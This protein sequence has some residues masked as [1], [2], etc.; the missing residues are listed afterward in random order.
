MSPS[1]GSTDIVKNG[2]RSRAARSAERRTEPPSHMSC[3]GALV[4]VGVTTIV[5]PRHSNGSPDQARRSTWTYSSNSAPRRVRSTPA[6]SNSSCRY[7]RPATN[8]NRPPLVTSSVAT[9]SAKRIGSCNGTRSAFTV[10][11]ARLVA[12]SSKPARA[13]GADAKSTPWCSEMA[14]PAKPCSSAHRAISRHCAYCSASITVENGARRRSNR[15]TAVAM[16]SSTDE[17]RCAIA[18]A[19]QQSDR[20]AAVPFRAG[21]RDP[22][23]VRD[24]RRRPFGDFSEEAEVLDGVEVR[25]AFPVGGRELADRWIAELLV[26][27]FCALVVARQGAELVKPRLTRREEITE[28][29]R[30]IAVL[31]DELD[32]YGSGL[33]D[34]DLDVDARLG[35]AVRARHLERGKHVE[36]PDSEDARP[37]RRRA[38]HVVD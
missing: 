31:L 2:N 18:V 17:S 6:I 37:A 27:R 10:T 25:H 29:A 36:R 4:G 9:A 5:R 7:A 35:A 15:I 1:S 24:E 22:V 23:E 3:S 28:H 11:C 32:L 14:T 38:E 33:R 19:C 8:V 13:G 26:V 30:A 12:P 34:R 16:R 20:V 21:T